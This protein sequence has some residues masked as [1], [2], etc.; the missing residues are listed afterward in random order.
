M[1]VSQEVRSIGILYFWKKERY[2]KRKEISRINFALVLCAE[3]KSL[4]AVQLRNPGLALCSAGNTGRVFPAR[5]TATQT[6]NAD[7]TLNLI[8]MG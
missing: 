3:K 1:T 5:Y 6:A 8:R 7:Q 4:L 2:E